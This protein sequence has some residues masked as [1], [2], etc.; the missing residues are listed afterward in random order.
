MIPRGVR[1]RPTGPDSCKPRLSATI[2]LSSIDALSHLHL[3]IAS[4][5]CA[6]FQ[7]PRASWGYLGAFSGPKRARLDPSQSL[8]KAPRGVRESPKMGPRRTQCYFETRCGRISLGG[9]HGPTRGS[10]EEERGGGGSFP[11]KATPVDRCFSKKR[12]ATDGTV[13][14]RFKNTPAGP[15]F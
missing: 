13:A 2:S 1:V 4:G 8:N 9:P 6:R 3:A 10:E 14:D 7:T 15:F 5:F 11:R 12:S